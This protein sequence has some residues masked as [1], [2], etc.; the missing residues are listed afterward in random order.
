MPLLEKND[1][2]VTYGAEVSGSNVIDGVVVDFVVVI[3][4]VRMCIISL[5]VRFEGKRSNNKQRQLKIIA[6]IETKKWFLLMG[7]ICNVSFFHFGNKGVFITFNTINVS[8]KRAVSR[9][10]TKIPCSK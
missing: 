6:S 8:T 9:H 4:C 10:F 1:W 2:F 3:A 5:N 7:W